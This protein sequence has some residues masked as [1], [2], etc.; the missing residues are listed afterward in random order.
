MHKSVVILDQLVGKALHKNVEELLNPD[1]STAQELNFD[2]FVE[3]V[4]CAKYLANQGI[5]YRGTTVKNDE[6]HLT[7]SPVVTS[8][9][10]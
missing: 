1:N 6:K 3:V 9:L 10:C 5:S 4:R 7:Q 8:R 2:G